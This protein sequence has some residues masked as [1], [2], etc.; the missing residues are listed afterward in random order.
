MDQGGTTEMEICRQFK[1][2]VEAKLR[3][4]GN[5]WDWGV[6]RIDMYMLTP[7][8][9]VNSMLCIPG[10]SHDLPPAL[11][12]P[13]SKFFHLICLHSPSQIAANFYS[14]I[15]FTSWLIG[16]FFL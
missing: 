8:W 10:L 1:I 6:R 12:M 15:L 14:K 4:L 13:L 5:G 2:M 3:R 11:K 7:L 9:D 16:V